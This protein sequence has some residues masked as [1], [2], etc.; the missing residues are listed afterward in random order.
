[1]MKIMN[2]VYLSTDE[3]LLSKTARAMS[4]GVTHVILHQHLFRE[5]LR[6]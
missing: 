6:D 2:N 1:M 3:W 4:M 5:P